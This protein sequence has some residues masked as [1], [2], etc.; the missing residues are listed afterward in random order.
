MSGGNLPLSDWAIQ[1]RYHVE[2]GARS[3]ADFSEK[4]LAE[5]GE[6]V[7][8]HLQALFEQANGKAVLENAKEATETTPKLTN[9]EAAVAE[10]E[11]QTPLSRSIDKT[12]RDIEDKFPVNP[13]K[14]G[15]GTEPKELAVLNKEG[16]PEATF[17]VSERA[18]NLRLKGIQ[19]LNPGTGAGSRALKALTD[20]ADKN[21]V[22]MEL[23][24][25]PYGDETTRLNSDQLKEWYSRHGF[26]PEEG[27][28]PS[29]GYMVRNPEERR[30]EER[31]APL[32]AKETEEAMAKRKPFQN[33]F[34]VTEG[35]KETIAKD[36]NM[37][38][39]PAEETAKPTFD[40]FKDADGKPDRLEITHKGEPMG[41]LKIEEQVPGTWTIKDA[42][43]KP[44]A[45]RQGFGKAALEQTIKE[46]KDAGAKAIESDVSQS[47]KANAMWS[48]VQR[49][50][51]EA[52]TEENGQYSLK[53][54]KLGKKSPYGNVR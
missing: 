22:T 45:Q 18:G 12:I 17:T 32:N 11:K 23:T 10:T 7:R 30:E 53:L 29:L 14:P 47:T 51:P 19:S 13:D 46:A 31:K 8:P 48:A 2:A 24:A 54:S 50:H 20:I 25:S 40:M 33:A 41:H 34:D 52:V 35:A 37:P 43:V 6:A 28:D 27:H 44:G 49:E 21:H 3:F 42:A 4:M 39:H 1:A 5:V 26:V 9:T 15:A 16:K 36:K 38:R